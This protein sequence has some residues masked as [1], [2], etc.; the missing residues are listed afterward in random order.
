MATKLFEFIK[1]RR[2]ELGVTQAEVR[3]R[4]L[5]VGVRATPATYSAWENG[6]TVPPG[7]R[8]EALLDVLRVLG[9]ERDVARRL[10]GE[11]DIRT[12]RMRQSQ[13]L[14]P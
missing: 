13:P 5:G 4:L 14:S 1:A 3:E 11:A 12:A 2:R 8:F 7:P 6:H 10:K 9:S